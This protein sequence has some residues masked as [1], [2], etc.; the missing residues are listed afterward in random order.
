M[1]IQIGLKL[2][3]NLARDQLEL[4][5]RPSRHAWVGRLMAL[6][7]AA[8]AGAAAH[9]G[10]ARVQAQPPQLLAALQG[11]QGLEQS[12]EHTRLQLR[13]AEARSLELERQVDL[14]NQR[15][16]ASQEEVTFFRKAVN[17]K[18]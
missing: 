17:G 10:V 12:L 18:R 1:T 16:H 8:L 9:H 6:I 5:P 2:P 14:L 4:L 7:V 11:V 15:L 3:A 13:V